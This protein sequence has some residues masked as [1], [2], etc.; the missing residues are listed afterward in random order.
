MC[1]GRVSVCHKPVLYRND[2][3]NPDGF[4]HE[5]FLPPI[6]HCVI[7]PKEIW[8]SPKLGYFP[9]GLCSKFDLENFATVNR[10]RCKQHSSSTTVKF[11]DD[12]YTT[13]DES[14]PFTT[15]RSTT[16]L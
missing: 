1:C 3:T 5:G 7:G 2:W 8:V 14:W 12:T 6:P 10:S 15:S 9:L 11:V 16:T 13:I 4:G